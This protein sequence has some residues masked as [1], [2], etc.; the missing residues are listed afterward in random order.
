MTGALDGIRVIDFGHYIAGPLAG[1]LL[2]DQGAD[3][4][5]VDPPGGPR[6]QTL[7]CL[8]GTTVPFLNRHSFSRHVTTA[9]FWCRWPSH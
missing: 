6:W 7:D 4:V 8:A 1:M 5:K 2:A 9:N 3:V